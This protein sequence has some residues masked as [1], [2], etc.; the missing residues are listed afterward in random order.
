MSLD[1]GT[2][3]CPCVLDARPYGGDRRHGTQAPGVAA[4]RDRGTA[5]SAD[6]LGHLNGNVRI[7]RSRQRL[8]AGPITRKMESPMIKTFGLT[9]TAAV[10]AL[11]TVADAHYPASSV[12]KDHRRQH[13]LQDN[14]LGW[15]GRPGCRDFVDRG[16]G[17]HGPGDCKNGRRRH[18][19]VH[20]AG[21]RVPRRRSGRQGSRCESIKRGYL[22]AIDL[23]ADTLK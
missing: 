3:S 7:M 22:V 23:P 19:C 2:V 21:G 12:Q 16:Q 5:T 13:R 14:R 10:L 17:L 18:V 9:V 4:G 8:S 6:R 20:G 1:I 11:S 15:G